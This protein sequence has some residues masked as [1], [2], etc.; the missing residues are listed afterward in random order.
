MSQDP[1]APYLRQADELFA[2]GDLVKAG[3]IWQAILKRE[4]GHALAR[5]RLLEVKR[6]LEAPATPPVV[7]APVPPPAPPVVADAAPAMAVE[8]VPPPPAVA[9]PAPVPAPPPGV[10][11]ERLVIE[12]CTLYDMGQLEDALKKWEMVLALDPDHRLAREYANGARRDLGLPPLGGPAAPAPLEPEAGPAAEEDLDKLLHEA[13][14][15]YDIGLVEDAVSKWERALALDPGRADV[16]AY[17]NQARAELARRTPAPAPTQAAAPAVQSTGPDPSLLDLKL[18]QAEHLL[19]LQRPEEAAFTFQQ[20]L[21]LDPGNARARQGLERC[22]R[23]EPTA[24]PVRPAAAALEL[25]AQGRIPMA[26]AEPSD[27]TLIVEAPAVTPPASLVK[28]AAPRTGLSLSLPTLAEGP[29]AHLPWLREPRV[30][31][32][33]GG[34]LV[35]LL[36]GG[37]VIHRYRKDQALKEAVQSARAAA[38]APVSREAQ[39]VDLAESPADIRQEAE[40]ALDQGDALRAY[41]RAGTLL[42]RNPGDAAAADLLERSKAALPGGAVGAS[43]AEYQKHL[44]AGDLDA[45]AKVMDALLRAAPDDVDLRQR[46][47]RLQL[48]LCEAHASQGKWDEAALDLQRGRALYPDDRAWQARLVLLK[49]VKALPKNQRGDWIGLLG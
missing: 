38:L 24:A 7:A 4:P 46:A 3:Q 6:R 22:R 18:R 14:Q 9:V 37:G 39:A 28:A 10:E 34:G 11:P 41:L 30:L 26:V 23:P 29:L 21:A 33:L 48:A 16:R 19:T 49:Q 1:Y 42:R 25:D 35:V 45:A 20:A 5:T 12:G 17:L 15:L 31:A 40:Q 44:Q 13:V 2:A 47:A 8:P 32:M 27:I 43:L 36:L